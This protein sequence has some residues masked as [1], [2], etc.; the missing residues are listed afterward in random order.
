MKY[1]FSFVRQSAIVGL[2]A[3]AT[4][5]SAH[6]TTVSIDAK[7]R[8]TYNQYGSA[9]ATPNA[10][11]N[12]FA[13]VVV[14]PIYNSGLP[15]EFR[16]FFS[17]DLGRTIGFPSGDP[18]GYTISSAKLVLDNWNKEVGVLQ[19]NGTNV[20]AYA[21]F[22]V[23]TGNPF[24]IGNEGPKPNPAI[25]DDLGTGIE[26]G[27]EL[28]DIFHPG[29]PLTVNLNAAALTE[30]NSLDGLFIVGGRAALPDIRTQTAGVFGGSWEGE[31]EGH[32]FRTQLVLEVEPNQ[33]PE[34][35]SL[36]LALGTGLASLALLRRRRRF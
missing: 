12:Y 33:V 5:A 22:D 7:W 1:Q 16:N 14:D 20:V 9:L 8:G 3:M 4:L 21:L 34:P 25:F 13:G 35:S 26:Y 11:S 27:F 2:L 23:T 10:T 19:P 30:L 31:Y 18:G 24:L 17:F 29:E 36:Q 32:P 28:A 6:A 15:T